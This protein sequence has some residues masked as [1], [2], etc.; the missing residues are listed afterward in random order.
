MNDHP[1]LVKL[2]NKLKGIWEARDV[3]AQRDALKKELDINE[4]IPPQIFYC[5]VCDKDYFPRRIVKIEQDDWDNGGVYRYW[6]SKHCSKWHRRLIN[7]KIKDK[8]WRKSPSVIRDR[9]L[10]SLDMIQPQETGFDM[11]YGKKNA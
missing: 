9:R 1:D 2:E 5:D 10:N 3:E 6:R 4:D 7:H 8:F 11:L